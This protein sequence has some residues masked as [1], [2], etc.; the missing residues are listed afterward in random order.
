M[1]TQTS[2][3]IVLPALPDQPGRIKELPTGARQAVGFLGKSRNRSLSKPV[4]R[5]KPHQVTDQT[6]LTVRVVG[7]A[8]GMEHSIP[9]VTVGCSIERFGTRGRWRGLGD[10]E[11]ATVEH[12]DW[13]NN[14]R[15]H[16]EIGHIPPAEYEALQAIASPVTQAGYQLTSSPSNP[17]LTRRRPSSVPRP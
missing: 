14:R 17:G 6:G 4:A 8:G 13:Y 16:G 15:P 7:V 1:F 3:Y 9:A 5:R 11:I 10:R 2:H 12:I